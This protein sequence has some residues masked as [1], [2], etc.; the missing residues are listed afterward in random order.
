MERVPTTIE[1]LAAMFNTHMASKQ[2]ITERK[3]EM[4]AT[5]DRLTTRLDRIEHLLFAEQKREIA[6]GRDEDHKIPKRD[7]P[8]TTKICSQRAWLTWP[9]SWRV[10]WCLDSSYPVK[11]LIQ[12]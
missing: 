10:L 5:E 12:A 6:E 8:E 3:Q 11:S 1:E 2:D 4:R 9:T 7:E